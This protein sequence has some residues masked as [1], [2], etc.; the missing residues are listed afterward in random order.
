MAQYELNLRDY[1]RVLRRRKLIVIF[2]AVS[3]GFFSFFFASLQKPIPLYRA[4]SSVK[5]EQSTTAAGLYAEAFN[6]GETSNL[7]TQSAIIKSIPIMEFVAKKL[8]LIDEKLTPEEIRREARYINR[9]LGIRNQISTSIE[10]ITSIIDIEAVDSDPKFAQK[11]ANTTAEV[12]K[13]QH[14][15]ERNKRIIEAKKYIENQLVVVEEKLRVTQENLRSFREKNRLVTIESETG[16]TLRLLNESEK[17]Y[18][19]AK[20]EKAEIESLIN[21]LKKQK[22][23]PKETVEGFYAEKVG[24]I[25]STL[26]TKLVDLYAQRDLLMLDYNANHPE[27]QRI[28][29]QIDKVI[30]NMINHLNDQ[31]KRLIEREQFLSDQIVKMK[32]KFN[33]LPRIGFELE[34]IEHELN[35]NKNLYAS[36]KGKHQ[37]VLISDAEKIEEVSL[38]R[39]ALLPRSPINPPTT[40]RT[41]A[42]GTIVGLILGLV[43]A[44]IFETMD[45]SIGT[46]EDVEGF[47]GVPVLGVV[48]FIRTEEIEET[49]VS[50][51]GMGEGGAL[52][53]RYTRLITHFSPKSTVAESFR[54]LRTGVK[55]LCLEKGVKTLLFS[56]STAGEGKSTAAANL[57]ITFAQIGSK[58]LLVDVDLRK[59]VVNRFFGIEREPGLSDV[60]LGNY[61]WKETV[62]TVTDLM[63][64][65]LSMEEIMLTPGFDNLNIITSGNIPPNPSEILNS[66]RMTEFINQVKAAYDVVI[67][68][69]T[70]ILPA[71]DAAILGSKT[72]GVVI[73]YRVGKIARGALKRAK[74][75]MDHVKA[76]V[77]GIVLNGLKP[78]VSA[79]YQH[80]GYYRYYSYGEKGKGEKEKLPW[81][82][83]IFENVKS[84]FTKYLE[85]TK[86]F[87]GFFRKKESPQAEEF[88]GEKTRH[89]RWW[90]KIVLLAVSLI[91]LIVGLLWQFEIL[92]I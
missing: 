76:N 85:K 36:L 55:F 46:I 84:F 37:E 67:F 10:G 13:E 70:P 2:A 49:L 12:Y 92:R 41:A 57:A 22:A 60:I 45:T 51:E 20:Q 9:V 52:P 81:Y 8:G 26:N 14:T 74:T 77:L 33:A 15:L 11:L 43:I 5:V 61:D 40:T 79:D 44:F 25:F 65:K 87:S 17:E 50:K 31:I 63:M 32:E 68:D 39:P 71:T 56:S 6:Y 28:D 35:I 83:K 88:P 19:Y 23:L 30:S 58:T 53:E 80:Y 47:L 62:R 54:T 69:T 7:D 73:V 82:K 91:A 78:E 18:A 21:E 72:D 29:V 34:R 27:I 90:I 4:V 86:S 48:P 38:V 75:Q 42:I 24:P 16:E 1:L 3:L 64:G 66:Q 59:P 89:W